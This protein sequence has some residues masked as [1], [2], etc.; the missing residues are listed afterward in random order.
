M[1]KAQKIWL[2]VSLAMFVVPEVL[3]SFIISSV[4]SLFGKNLLPL[5]TIFI[6]QQFFTDHPV[7]LFM[8]LGT[9]IVGLLILLILNLKNKK[10]II[11]SILLSALLLWL[12]FVFYIGY[13][14]AFRMSFP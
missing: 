8:L 1:T 11:V 6:K 5:Y 13:A 2:W 3:C 4:S 14:I 12:L 9:E 10:N 7:Y